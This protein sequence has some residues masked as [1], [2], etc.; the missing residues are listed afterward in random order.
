MSSTATG[1]AEGRAT[2]RADGTALS[3][4][5]LRT[6]RGIAIA[7]ALLGLFLDQIAKDLAVARLDPADPPSYFGGL[8]HLQLLRNSGAAF[9]MGSGATVVISLF[10]IVALVTVALLV[11]PRA[12]HRW[13][14]VSCGMILAGI[15]GN[16]ADR[17]FRAPGALRGHVVDF[18]ALP[19]FAVFNVADMFITATAVLV[20]AMSIFGGSA[21]EDG[22][23]GR[24]GGARR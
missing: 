1:A 15:S 14:L 3:G 6:W 12:R 22:G 7:I 9:S 17:L 16:L 13:S 21:D 4:P 18:F 11:L 5:R 8:L 10:A 20:V 19:H 23:S 2:G 24:S